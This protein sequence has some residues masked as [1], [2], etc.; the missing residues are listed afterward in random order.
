PGVAGTDYA[1]ISGGTSNDSSVTLRYLTTGSKT[2]TINYTTVPN[3]CTATSATSS[4][5]TTVNAL[6]T[7]TFTAQPAA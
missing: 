7:P 5:A 6:P 3:S 4:S 2:V 1:I